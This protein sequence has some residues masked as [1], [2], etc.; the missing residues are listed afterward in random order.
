MSVSK[1]FSTNLALQ[2][3]S[4]LEQKVWLKVRLHLNSVLLLQA[5]VLVLLE[6]LVHMARTDL[7]ELNTASSVTCGTLA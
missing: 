5:R 6:P 3:I 7:L 1:L 4:E 2:G